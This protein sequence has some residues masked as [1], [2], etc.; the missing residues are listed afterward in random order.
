MKFIVAYLAILAASQ[1]LAL[2]RVVKI[3]QFHIFLKIILNILA[4]I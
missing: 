3:G 1:T 2:P 4:V